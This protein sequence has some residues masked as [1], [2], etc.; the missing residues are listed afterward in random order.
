MRMGTN[1]HLFQGDNLLPMGTLPSLIVHHNYH[2]PWKVF[3][4][5]PNFGTIPGLSSHTRKC[6]LVWSGV[7]GGA[8]GAPVLFAE[9]ASAPRT[10]YL[11]FT[12]GMLRASSIV[13]DGRSIV[14][15][16]KAIAHSHHATPILTSH[17]PPWLPAAWHFCALSIHTPAGLA[18]VPALDGPREE[19]PSR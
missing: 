2:F 17:R 11:V 1:W 8:G 15:L 19:S 10:S 6:W 9:G 12:R 7:E 4:Q 13:G 3:S 16:P 5:V 14:A 18:I